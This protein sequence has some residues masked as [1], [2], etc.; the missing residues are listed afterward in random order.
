MIRNSTASRSG[1][2]PAPLLSPGEAHLECC[3]QSWAPQDKRDREL[4][5]QLQQST[6]LAVL[7]NNLTHWKKLP[8]LPSLTNQPHQVLASDPVPF[9]DLQQVSRAGLSPEPLGRSPGTHPHPGGAVMLSWLAQSPGM[10]VGFMRIPQHR[11]EG[12][13]MRRTP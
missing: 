7:S 10:T 6:H 9:A 2:N 4:L 5:E 8:L 3:V 11:K 13:M 12:R 1:S